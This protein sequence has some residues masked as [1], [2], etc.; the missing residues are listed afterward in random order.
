MKLVT[1]PT[2]GLRAPNATHV[3]PKFSARGAQQRTLCGE[4]RGDFYVLATEST[5]ASPTCAWCYRSLIELAEYAARCGAV[6]A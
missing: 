6:S 4:Q 5:D 2:V 1:I 3:V